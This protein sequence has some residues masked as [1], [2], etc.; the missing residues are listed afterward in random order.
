MGDGEA[1]QEGKSQGSLPQVKQDGSGQPLLAEG[2]ENDGVGEVHGI[3]A[4]GAE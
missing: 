4:A 2:G 1:V 3:D